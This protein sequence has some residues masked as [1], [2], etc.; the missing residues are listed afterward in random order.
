M[1]YLWVIPKYA[2]QIQN[3]TRPPSWK[4]D[5]L[6]Y[7]SNRFADFDE[8]WYGDAYW[9]SQHDLLN[10]KFWKSN[11]A[12]GRHFENRKLRYLQNRLDDF[13]EILHVDEY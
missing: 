11:M 8:I 1:Y 12:D 9:P 5:E 2:P 3:G 6:L 10:F 4:N 7:L 13:D